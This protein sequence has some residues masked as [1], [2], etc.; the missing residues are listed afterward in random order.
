VELGVSLERALEAASTVPG[1]IMGLPDLGEIRPGGPADI[2]VLDDELQVVRAIVGEE[3][4]V[5]G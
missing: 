3:S 5:P 1:R 2:V 4:R